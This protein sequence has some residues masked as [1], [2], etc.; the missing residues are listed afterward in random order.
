MNNSY[1][2]LGFRNALHNHWQVSID[3]FVNM[4]YNVVFAR[5]PIDIK[6]ED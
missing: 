5:A 4:Y 1:K 6:V 2:K 3:I